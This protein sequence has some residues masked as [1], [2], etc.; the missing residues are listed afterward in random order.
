MTARVRVFARAKP[1]DKLEIVKSLQRQ[2]LVCAMS[3]WV[4]TDDNFTSIVKAVEK[5]RAIYS[6][7]QKFVA[8]IMSVHI[9]EAGENVRAYIC[10]SFSE[11]VWVDLCTNSVMQRAVLMAQVAMLCAVLIPFFSTD[12]LGLDG[13]HIGWWGWLFSLV[14]PAATLVLCELCKLLTK[15]LR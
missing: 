10:R 11:P 3:L 9:A 7:I 2:G 14:G 8:F 12:I 4:L 15:H 5:G 6:G 13:L 1:A